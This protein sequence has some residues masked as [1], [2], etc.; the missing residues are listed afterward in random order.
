MAPQRVGWY[1]DPNDNGAEVYWDGARWHGSRQKSIDESGPPVQPTR[2]ADVIDK[3][4]DAWQQLARWV[5]ILIVV[6]VLLCVIGVIYA[7]QKSPYEDECKAQAN[8]MNLKNT[9]FDW[10][11]KYCIKNG[12]MMGHT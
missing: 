10:Y 4:K 1:P 12:E 5:Q 8:E 6:V 11:V 2:P 3:L 7:L 9:D